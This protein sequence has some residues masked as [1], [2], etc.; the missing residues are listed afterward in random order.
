[1]APKSPEKLA[2]KGARQRSFSDAD[3]TDVLLRN[4]HAGKGAA[5]MQPLEKAQ[6]KDTGYKEST[7]FD[8]GL[9]MSNVSSL[10][11]SMHIKRK[12]IKIRIKMPPVVE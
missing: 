6:I 2:G 7:K 12:K 3:K 10:K 4:L 9:S 1:M 11:N 5:A 8:S